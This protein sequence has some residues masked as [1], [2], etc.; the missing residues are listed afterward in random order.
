MTPWTN[1]VP[2]RHEVRVLAEYVAAIEH[3]GDGW[4]YLHVGPS[5]VPRRRRELVA[6]K[7]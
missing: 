5:R 3:D 4:E 7:F 2:R 1:S 6:S